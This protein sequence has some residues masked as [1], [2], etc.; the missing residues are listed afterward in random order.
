GSYI[1]LDPNSIES[2]TAG[3]YNV[4]SAHFAYSGPAS[5]TATHPDYPKSLSRQ[6][7]RINVPQAANAPDKGWARMP[8]TLYADGAP[9][10]KGILDN[11]GQL[12]IEHQVVTRQYRLELANGVTYQI[13]IPTEYDNVEQGV[14]ANSGLHN[15]RSQP[16]DSLSQPGSHTD[17]RDLY[18]AVLQGLNDDQ[19]DK[20]Q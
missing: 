16:D 2:G 20:P 15:H 1:T 10:Q 4:K 9:L 19:E 14:L 5:M 7:L 12:L 6:S 8:Y 17:H 11:T 13:P 3:D 18:A